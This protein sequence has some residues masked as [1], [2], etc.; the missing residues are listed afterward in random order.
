MKYPIKQLKV[1]A[2][3]LYSPFPA[4]HSNLKPEGRNKLPSIYKQN[5]QTYNPEVFYQFIF[6]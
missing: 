5:T 1:G 4:D 2:K 6:Q 3:A